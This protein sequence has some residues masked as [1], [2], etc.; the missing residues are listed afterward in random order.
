MEALLPSKWFE[1][2]WN[3]KYKRLWQIFLMEVKVN[4]Q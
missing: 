3:R 1:K 4:S 2:M